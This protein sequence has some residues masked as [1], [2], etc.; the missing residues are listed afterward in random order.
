M[1]TRA[2]YLLVGLFVL[3]MTAALF[4]FA[5]WLGR[6]QFES[7][8]ERYEIYF[9][10]SVTGLKKGSQVSY[11]GITVGEVVNLEID[12]QNFERVLVTI[13]VQAT[14]PVRADTIARLEIQGIAGVPFVM[15]TGGTLS[16]PQLEAKEGEP[17]PVI[18]SA[19]SRLEELLSGAPELVGRIED[20]LANA[21]ELLG[22]KN[23]E[24]I[25]N[26][27]ANFEA[28][29][30]AVADKREDISQAVN[31]FTTTMANLRDASAQFEKLVVDV[32]S[33]T[34]TLAAQ[35]DTTL[36]SFNNAATTVDR[37][38]K[39][40]L[41]DLR[42]ASR[43]IAMAADEMASLVNENR[44][45]L[46]NFASTGLS[47]FNAFVNESR[48]LVDNLNRISTEFERD[49]ARFLFGNQQQ[50]YDAQTR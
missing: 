32:Q 25:S 23:R 1:E 19:P 44:G 50:G 40:L 29:S 9:V 2:N 26:T 17:Y 49:P 20:L 22:P 30:D 41:E 27:L 3:V 6:A 24:S 38:V 11:R 21:N 48:Q 33:R 43:S 34:N 12:P 42:K 31:D 7:N 13:E 36:G 37:E 10:G 46:S 39:P 16:S 14:T 5:L 15:L 47:D 35:A 18:A 4:I 45:P 8:V 28:V